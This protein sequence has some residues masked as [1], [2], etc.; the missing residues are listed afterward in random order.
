V[1]QGISQVVEVV[2][3][4]MVLEPLAQVGQAVVVMLMRQAQDLMELL[5]LDQVA[6][7]VQVARVRLPYRKHMAVMVEAD[8]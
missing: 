6:V 7:E 8:L 5:T 2:V 3:H 1:H 4:M